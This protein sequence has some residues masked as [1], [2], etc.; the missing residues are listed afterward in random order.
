MISQFLM[1]TKVVAGIGAVSEVAKE[2]KL[3]GGKK[4]LIITDPGLS[5]A[6]LPGIVAGH[7]QAAGIES[8][9]FDAVESDPSITTASKAA[10]AAKG[11]AADVLVAVGGGSAID[12][13]KSAGV[14]VTSG[15]YLR[16]FGGVGKVSKPTLPLIAIPT[17]AGTGSEVT[18]FAVMTDTDKDEKFTISSPLIAPRAA[19]LDPELTVKL[20]ASITAFTG[21]DA[22]THAVEAYVSVNAQPA[23]DA[24]AL[25]AI[26]LIMANLPVAVHRGDN[27]KARENMLQAA[28]LAGVAFNCAF[29]GLSHALASPLG[30]HFHVPHGLANAVMLPYVM[31]FNR[32]AAVERFAV[33]ATT[34]GLG[35]AGE[36]PNQLAEKTIAAVSQLVRDI[37]IPVHLREVGAKQD[38]LPQVASDALKSIQLKFNP[39]LTNE[40][41]I[42]GLLMHAF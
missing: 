27:L 25:Y 3:L 28:L 9:V 6:G 31:E 4:V 32:P 14:L 33:I 2:V 36:P 38:M 42:L 13:A 20:P 8:C 21:M 26:K 24:L 39:R 41:E 5:K 30:A 16:D 22:L 40:R 10:E 17:T 1:S 12:A 19:I 34:L 7:L 35:A 29:L 18:V 15:G 23:S 11:F 37:N